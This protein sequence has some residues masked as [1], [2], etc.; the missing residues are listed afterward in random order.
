MALNVL[1]Q[2]EHVTFEE[3]SCLGN[4]THI[5]N[6]NIFKPTLRTME[7]TAHKT[8]KEIKTFLIQAMFYFKDF[9]LLTF[10]LT[11]SYNI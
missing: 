4:F 5:V 11:A 1:F 7:H 9:N 10:F 8:E 3:K 6:G 2:R